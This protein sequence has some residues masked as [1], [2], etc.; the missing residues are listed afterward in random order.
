MGTQEYVKI[1]GCVEEIIYKNEVTGF[2]VLDI[3]VDNELICAVGTMVSV[4]PGEELELT[5]YF[6]THPV[7]GEQFK[8]Q[9]V[10]RRL[11]ATSSAIRRYLSSGVVK[12]IGPATARNIVNCFGDDTLKIIEESPM[13]L[14]EVPGISA[15]KAQKLAG[16]FAQVFGVRTLMMFLSKYQIT[17]MQSVAIY[18][19]WGTGAMDLIKQN[20]YILSRASFGISFATADAMALAF[21]LPPENEDRIL[22]GIQFVLKHNTA[23]GHTG[24]PLR[25]LLPTA[26]RMLALSESVVEDTLV[27]A[28]ESGELYR[29]EDAPDL[30]F[31]PEY[32]MAQQNI[33]SRLSLMLSV[34]REPQPQIEDAISLIEEEKGIC[35]ESLQRKA[36]AQA[37]Q[38]PV[39]ILTGGPGTGKTTTVNGMIELFEQQGKTVLL[40]AP[41]GRAAKRMTEVTGREAKTIHRLLEVEPGYAQTGKLIFSHNEQN[42]LYGDVVIVD[43][44]SMVDTLLFDALLRGMKPTAKLVLVGDFHQL[45]SVG[46][47][48]VLRDLIESDCVPTV[49]LTQIFRQAAKSLIVTNAHAIV[50]GQ[51]PE[52]SKK[53]NDFFFLPQSDTKQAAQLIAD[54]CATR[55]PHTYGFSPTEDI[56]VLCPQRKGDLGVIVLNQYLQERLNPAADTKTQWKSPTYLFREQDKVMQIRNNYDI[57]WKRGEE[58]GAGIFNGDIGIIRMIDRGS[59]TMAV[60][61]DSK[62]AYYSFDMSKELELAYAVTV[63]KSQGSEFD[64][65]IVPVMGGYDK[66]Y[67]R[68]LLYTAVTRAKKILIL[69]GQRSRIS[70]M[71]QNDKKMRRYTGLSKMLKER[72]IS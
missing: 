62:I 57:P 18:K 41:T 70:F 5:G 52:L 72:V 49:S 19:E 35:Y 29:M 65:I 13:R 22:A 9:M 54:L 26:A 34:Y 61:F 71:V 47:G 12:G 15:A 11:P 39:F 6:D 30:I 56:Q 32:Y 27:R 60:D 25:L 67:F 46:A 2:C 3:S 50:N 21:H 40:T 44:V 8:V 51:M 7:H 48:N 43:E 53:D 33:V 55:L 28:V 4:E 14:A 59:R 23:N 66:L 38:Q 31:L 37:A 36:I 1:S 58:A 64:A 69:V 45:P 17:P 24:L 10:E 42:P 68:N 16:A 20:P 63:H